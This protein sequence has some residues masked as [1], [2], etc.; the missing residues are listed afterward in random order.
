MVGIFSFFGVWKGFV[1]EQPNYS[2]SLVLLGLCALVAALV[3][4]LP[5][6]L[7]AWHGLA[8]WALFLSVALV[9]YF[10]N[11]TFVGGDTINAVVTP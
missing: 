8:L 4:Y 3:G 2:F 1:W 11:G 5:R 6:K 10:L 7:R 9:Q